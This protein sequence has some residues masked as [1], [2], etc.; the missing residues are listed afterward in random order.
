MKTRNIQ[1]FLMVSAAFFAM[2]GTA[3]SEG[4]SVLATASTQMLQLAAAGA[5][6]PA[7]ASA[8]TNERGAAQK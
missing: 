5:P 4:A 8:V 6:A 1:N 3:R 7:L 2:S